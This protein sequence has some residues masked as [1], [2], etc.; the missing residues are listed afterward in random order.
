[1]ALSHGVNI[2][3]IAEQCGTSVEMIERNYGKFIRSDGDAPLRAL[4]KGK[5]ETFTETLRQDQS[6]K[7]LQVPKKNGATR[8][9]RTGD[10]L[11]TKN[12]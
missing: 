11:I 7:P 6:Y 4:L 3:W 10:L 5:T 8:Q 1:V 2:K 12:K 9:N